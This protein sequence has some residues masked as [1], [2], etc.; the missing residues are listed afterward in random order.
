MG[1]GGLSK[2]VVVISFVFFIIAFGLALGSEF[3]RSKVRAF[4]FFVI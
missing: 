2:L 3:K 1:N 4:C